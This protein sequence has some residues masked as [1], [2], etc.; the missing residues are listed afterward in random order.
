LI[1]S[2]SIIDDS[3]SQLADDALVQVWKDTELVST[4]K[5]WQDY[6]H[7]IA[8]K[9]YDIVLSSCWYLNYISY[10]EDWKKYYKC[11]PRDFNGKKLP[12]TLLSG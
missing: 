2:I 4:F 3:F 6:I 12:I 9:G 11:D 8:Q 10:G 5:S 1:P 7:P